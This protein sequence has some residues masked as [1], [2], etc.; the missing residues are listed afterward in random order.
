M[1]W[2]LEASV[3]QQGGEWLNKRFLGETPERLQQ[4]LRDLADYVPTYSE[5]ALVMN[6]HVYLKVV[7]RVQRSSDESFSGVFARPT[8]LKSAVKTPELKT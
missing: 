4:I 5:K 3:R 8:T 7:L 6:S 2:Q 1:E